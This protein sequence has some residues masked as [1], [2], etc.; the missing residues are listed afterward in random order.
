THI[1]DFKKSGEK[2]IPMVLGGGDVD[3]DSCLRAL[4][5]KGYRGYLSLEYE[6]EV[7]SKVGVEKSLKVLKESL[8]KTSS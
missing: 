2:I 8:Q 5:E 7:D 4:K 3:L 1:K 6:A